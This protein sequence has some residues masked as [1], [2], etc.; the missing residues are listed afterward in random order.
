MS[1]LFELEEDDFYSTE[2]ELESSEDSLD[3]LDDLEEDSSSNEVSVEEEVVEESSEDLVEESKPTETTIERYSSSDISYPCFVL[4]GSGVF[5]KYVVSAL[6]R[7][8]ESSL[9][10][11][12]TIKV[13]VSNGD[14]LLSLG[15]ISSLQVKA[16]IDLL[17]RNSIEAYYEKGYL[18]E[19]DLIYTLSI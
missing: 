9:S 11:E 14:E 16:V 18:L 8:I 7:M 4:N 12:D 1:E 5:P 10:L 13:Y 2:E 17:G 3:G 19:G 6:S 15:G